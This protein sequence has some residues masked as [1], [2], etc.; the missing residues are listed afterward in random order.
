MVLGF[1][2]LDAAW[3]I[4][5]RILQKKSPLRGDKKHL[6]H[7]LLEI[8]LSDRMTLMLIYVSCALFGLIA[9][10]L[11]GRQKL[12]AILILMAVMTAGGLYIVYFKKEKR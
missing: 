9:V 4:I 8:G 1:L 12:Y 5:R 6:H 2:I 11:S 7:R 3:V 10:F